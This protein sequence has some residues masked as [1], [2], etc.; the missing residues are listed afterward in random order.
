MAR[1]RLP[2]VVWLVGLPL[3]L[4]AC[5]EADGAS[6]TTDAGGITVVAREYGFTPDAL[7]L[8]AGSVQFVLRNEG[9]EEHEFEI[10]QGDTV[11]DEV[12]G[13]IPGLERD[14]SV[15]LA[16]GEYQFVCRLAD[17]LQRGMSGSLSVAG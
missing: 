4:A 12:E 17:H 3:T 8:P 5:G 10:L 14:L 2:S 13:L 9:S 1:R 6:A 16:P 11:V 7:S 15:T